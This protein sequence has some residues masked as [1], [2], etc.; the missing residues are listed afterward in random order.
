MKDKIV[1]LN[2][3]DQC[4]KCGDT[5]K[6]RAFQVNEAPNKKGYATP[7]CQ[8]ATCGFIACVGNDCDCGYVDDSTYIDCEGCKL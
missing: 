6:E 5:K 8:C 7:V 4:P 3:N 1:Y 2:K